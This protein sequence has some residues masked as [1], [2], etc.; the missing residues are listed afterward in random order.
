MDHVTIAN[1]AIARIG[2]I[3][4]ESFEAPGPSGSI[5]KDVYDAVIP[6]LLGKYPWHFTKKK[7]HLQRVEPDDPIIGWKYAYDVPNDGISPPRALYSDK[8]CR[9]P[10]LD[11]EPVG[12]HILTDAEAV[13][14]NYQWLA[15]PNF[16]PSYFRELAVLVVAAE[17]AGAI[18]E[19]WQLRAKFRIDA[20]GS[21]QYQGQGGQFAVCTGLDTQAAPSPEIEDRNPIM[22]ARFN[23]EDARDGWED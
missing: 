2:G 12:K 17:L 23:G 7:T 20:Y 6:D 22:A 1:Q 19:D 3:R 11:W 14:A 9:R 5:V 15:H 18:R 4:I 8:S 21:E 10:L 16:W 13:W